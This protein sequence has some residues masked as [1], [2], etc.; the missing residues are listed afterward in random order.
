M[1]ETSPVEAQQ[2]QF[3]FGAEFQRVLLRLLLEDEDFSEQLSSYLQP[4]YFSAD[5]LQW[6]WAY[7]Q[8]HKQQYQR[9][10]SLALLR[11][12]ALKLDAEQQG[13]YS[14]VLDQVANQVMDDEA[15]VRAQVLE[16]VRVN[17]FVRGANDWRDAFNG[18]EYQRAF[19]MVRQQ[20]DEIERVA[21]QQDDEAFFFQTTAERHQR[22]MT[23]DPAGDAIPTGLNSLDHVLRGGLSLGELGIWMAYAKVGKTTMLVNHGIAAT[24][25]AGRNTAHF[26][27]EGSRRLVED[28]YEA[29]FIRESY[30]SIRTGQYSDLVY[31]RMLYEYSQLG[32]KL[33]VCGFTDSWDYSVLNVEE[34]LKRV[35]R[36]F[37]WRPDCLIVDYGDL[38]NGRHPPYRSEH[39]KQKAAFRDLKSLA[40]RGY[41]LWTASQAQR[42]AEG[43]EDKPHILKGRQIADCYDKVRVADFLGSINQTNAE[44]D[45]QQMRIHAELYRDSAANIT[46]VIGANMDQMLLWENPEIDPVHED[47]VLASAPQAPKT[48]P[49]MMQ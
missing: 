32:N 23:Y 3:P 17:L 10:P 14:L 38:I 11:D 42:P 40:N 46:K 33:Y 12:V 9:N 15:Y 19:D 13:L 41:A 25:I 29:A 35:W 7:C 16:F 2:T 8:K 47:T 43:A 37:R 20:M 34:A 49:G 44:K 5:A 4:G 28:R 27:F 45:A 22:R 31:Q 39:E 21:W 6:A 26:V 18:G 1:P 48:I 30:G 36:R 24:R